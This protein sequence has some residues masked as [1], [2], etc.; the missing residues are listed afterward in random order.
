MKRSLR[1]PSALA[2]LIAASTACAHS[3]GAAAGAVR[4]ALNAQDVQGCDKVTVLKVQGSM[5][6]RHRAIEEMQALAKEKGAN[7]LLVA[8]SGSP[9]SGV[10]YRCSA[11]TS[12]SS[13]R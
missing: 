12:A 11:G 4:V 5:W 8:E 6:T 2:V 3:N 7:T 10:A 9:S 1:F 13:S